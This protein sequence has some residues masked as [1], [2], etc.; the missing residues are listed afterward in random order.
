[1]S[2]QPDEASIVEATSWLESCGYAVERV[3]VAADP[4]PDLIARQNNETIVVEVKSNANPPLELDATGVAMLSTS[5]AFSNSMSRVVKKAARQ[6]DHADGQVLRVICYVASGVEAEAKLDE[7]RA[8]VYGLVDVIELNSEAR[9]IPCFYFDHAEF[10]RHQG[11]AGVGLLWERGAQL[12]INEF[13]EHA[14]DFR[15]SRLYERHV[16]IEAVRDPTA[17]ENTGKAF[18][19]RDALE[20]K[21][22]TLILDHLRQ[23][24]ERGRLLALR[25]NKHTGVGF[26]PRL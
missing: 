13:C 14:P 2:S 23:K 20:R 24:Y 16:Q 25:W 15:S 12:C 11:L 10:F 19:V 26:V 8:T 17:E 5:L 4:R 6:L 21:N 9:A 1:V 18:V 22:E 3:P 7:F